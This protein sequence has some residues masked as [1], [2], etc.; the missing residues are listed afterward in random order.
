MSESE[1]QSLYSVVGG[2]DFVVGPFLD[3]RGQEL[4]KVMLVI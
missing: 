3:G 4:Q 1:L 2:D